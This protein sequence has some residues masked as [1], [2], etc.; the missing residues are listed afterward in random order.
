MQRPPLAVGPKQGGGA[1]PSGISL[2]FLTD[3]VTRLLD[4]REKRSGS[5]PP[6]S[7]VGSARIVKPPSHIHGVPGVGAPTMAYSTYSPM[8]IGAVGVGGHPVYPGMMGFPHMAHWAEITKPTLFEDKSSQWDQFDR[9]WRR[10]EQLVATSGIPM[11]DPLKLEVLKSRVGASSRFVLQRME[12]ENPHQ[13]LEFS[14]RP[15]RKNIARMPLN[16]LE[17]FGGAFS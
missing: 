13:P 7:T 12:E 3:H 17:I 6:E 16:K 15:W 11:P 9:E 10:Y 1:P 8:G 4:E 14:M 5:S 2:E